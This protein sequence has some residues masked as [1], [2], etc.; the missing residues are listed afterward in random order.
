MG[1]GKHRS[2]PS[3]RPKTQTPLPSPGRKLFYP[4]TSA[5][6]YLGAFSDLGCDHWGWGQEPGPAGLVDEVGKVITTHGERPAECF[7][8]NRTQTSLCKGASHPAALAEGVQHPHPF[9]PVDLGPL[10]PK[11]TLRLLPNRIPSREVGGGHGSASSSPPGLLHGPHH[12]VQ[13]P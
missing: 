5:F 7:H 10:C 8:G 12:D 1:P 6:I 11:S 3:T 9:F 2:S 4:A 13:Q